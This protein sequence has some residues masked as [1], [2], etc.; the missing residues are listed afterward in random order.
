MP[1]ARLL[2]CAS[3]FC[4]VMAGQGWRTTNDPVARESP[5]KSMKFF[6]FA[7]MTSRTTLSDGVP[8][9]SETLAVVPIH[10]TDRD[11]RTPQGSTAAVRAA[12]LRFLHPSVL[13]M[14]G[15]GR[16]G[17]AP[18]FLASV[19]AGMG[20][21]A[22]H[23]SASAVSPCCRRVTSQP[24]SA[25][26]RGVCAHSRRSVLRHFVA[27]VPIR[28]LPRSYTKAVGSLVLG[29]SCSGSLGFSYAV[30]DAPSSYVYSIFDHGLLHRAVL[31]L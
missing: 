20:G 25:D 19:L 26:P 18:P 1:R 17:K 31:G 30:F 5:V 3:C 21:G 10:A 27:H 6:S 23:R 11:N 22:C 13:R 2:W 9:S 12:R 16:E 14:R 29:D 24:A 15:P 7:L 28:L 4:R 8:F